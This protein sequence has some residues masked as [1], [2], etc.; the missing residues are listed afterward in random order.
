MRNKFE[1]VTWPEQ[2]V[3]SR[4][5]RLSNARSAAKGTTHRV[6]GVDGRYYSKSTGGK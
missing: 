2:R 4:H 3:V 6:R 1:V 5:Y